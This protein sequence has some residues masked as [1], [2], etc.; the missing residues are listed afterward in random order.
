MMPENSGNPLDHLGMSG[1]S[2]TIVKINLHYFT[3]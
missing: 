2:G 1:G 3:I